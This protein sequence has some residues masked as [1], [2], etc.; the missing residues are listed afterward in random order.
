[1]SVFIEFFAI[2]QYFPNDRFVVNWEIMPEKLNVS[3]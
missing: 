2:L 1:M 3:L